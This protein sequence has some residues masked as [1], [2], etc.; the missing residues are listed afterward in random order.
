VAKIVGLKL[1]A[2]RGPLSISP[3]GRSLDA[4]PVLST[5]VDIIRGFG[6]MHLSEDRGVR[7]KR[8]NWARRIDFIGLFSKQFGHQL[9]YPSI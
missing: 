1:N 5:E 3:A 2:S 6:V 8:T 7:T 4:V 9:G